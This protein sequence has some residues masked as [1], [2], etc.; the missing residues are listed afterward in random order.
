MEIK[1]LGIGCPNC[2]K[3]EENVRNAVKDMNLNAKIIK[4]DDMAKIA[5]YGVMSLPGLVINDEVV[6]TGMVLPSE[7]LKNIFRK[8]NS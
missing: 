8:Y 6:T 2:K 7:N 5:E 3:F 1:I 4:I